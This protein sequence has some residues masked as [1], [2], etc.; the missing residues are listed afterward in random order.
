MSGPSKTGVAL[1]VVLFLTAAGIS[2]MQ[3]VAEKPG[4]SEQACLYAFFVGDRPVRVLPC[5]GGDPLNVAKD[6]DVSSVMRALSISPGSVRFV[7]CNG[8]LFSTAEESMPGE[9][10]PGK[11]YVITYP[12]AEDRRYLAPITHELAHVL[13]LEATGSLERLRAT[14]ESKRIELA[15][16]FLTGVVFSRVLGHVDSAE[17]QHNLSQT[18]LY[19]DSSL[20]AHG[21]PTQRTA[22]FRRGRFFNFDSVAMSF[23]RASQ[24]FQDN[25]Y[26]QIIAVQ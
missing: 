2:A 16:D 19:R 18:G 5:T 20:L 9:V 23:P 21:D 11:R 17:F 15:A 14:L 26:A 10:R 4:G 24:E 22:A 8:V 12:A 6:G 25:I 13:Q 3:V 1:V 7:G